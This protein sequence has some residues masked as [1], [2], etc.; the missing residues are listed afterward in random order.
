MKIPTHKLLALLILFVFVACST[1]KKTTTS[2]IK[3]VVKSDTEVSKN[4]EAKQT[5]NFTDKSNI[6]E[7]KTIAQADLDS[8]ECDTRII[9][10]DTN[11]PIVDGTG[12]P[13][14]L[15][16]TVISNRKHV[17]KLATIT[18]K[19]DEQ[20]NVQSNYTMLLKSN[21]DSM[22]HINTSLISKTETKETPVPNNWL[23]WLLSGIVICLAVGLF[24]KFKG[25]NLVSFIWK[26]IRSIFVSK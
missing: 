11:K 14:V 2:N 4:T 3:E 6:V 24:L 20:K 1:V 23:K 26:F 17:K 15:R 16:E 21:I 9:D 19:K 8:S 22:Q 25:L 13:P 7:S 5:S 12:K 18:D 10:Y